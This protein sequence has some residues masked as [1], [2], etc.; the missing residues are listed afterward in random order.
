M[1]REPEIPRASSEHARRTMKANRRKDTSIERQ[2]RSKLFASG[3]RYR[4][5]F[6]PDAANKRRRADIVF[7]KARVAVFL[8]GC[9]WHGCAEHFIM[10]KTNADYWS[11]KIARNRARDLETN[12]RLISLGWAVRRYWEHQDADDIV[13]DLLALVR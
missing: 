4:V 10:P 7:T 9:F 13:R 3:V 1:T 12:E 2:V 5:D 6:A 8:D 11:A